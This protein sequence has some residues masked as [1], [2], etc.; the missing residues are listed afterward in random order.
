[1]RQTKV[2]KNLYISH[3]SEEPCD[4]VPKHDRLVCFV[5]IRR[6]G[7]T[8]NVPEIRLPLVEPD[9]RM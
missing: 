1:M 4:L 6:A 3:L 8:G 5:V 9:V 2:R 7:D